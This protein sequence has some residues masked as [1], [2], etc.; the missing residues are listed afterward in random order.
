MALEPVSELLKLK[1]GNIFAHLGLIRPGMNIGGKLNNTN[2]RRACNA[3]KR[4]CRINKEASPQRIMKSTTVKNLTTISDLVKSPIKN[5]GHIKQ[6]LAM[7][8]D[9]FHGTL[10]GQRMI[11]KALNLRDIELPLQTCEPENDDSSK[12]LEIDKFIK[13]YKKASSKKHKKTSLR[14]LIGDDIKRFK[15]HQRKI[16]YFNKARRGL[17]KK[18]RPQAG[19]EEDEEELW[20]PKLPLIFKPDESDQSKSVNQTPNVSMTPK[21]R[22]FL[23]TKNPDMSMKNLRSTNTSQTDIALSATSTS[24]TISSKV[25]LTPRKKMFLTKIDTGRHRKG[26]QSSYELEKVQEEIALMNLKV[27]D[28][29]K[30][31]SRKKLLPTLSPNKRRRDRS[32]D[33]DVRRKLKNGSSDL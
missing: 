12:L 18:S 29:I 16:S 8:G 15:I 33:K 31:S 1:E 4:I 21:P 22:H 11:K 17:S 14:D 27:L 30:E 10:R 23:I 24:Q 26:L 25:H 6:A 13:T 20:K 28:K 3:A 19:S 2:V 5:R 7:M 9:R 32:Q